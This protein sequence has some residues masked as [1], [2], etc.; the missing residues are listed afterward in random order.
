MI[1]RK[2]KKKIILLS[3]ITKKNLIKVVQEVEII[4]VDIILKNIKN[5]VAQVNLHLEKNKD[6][7]KETQEIEKNIENTDENSY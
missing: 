5:I 2:Q 1:K 4:K 7:V 3:V 6:T